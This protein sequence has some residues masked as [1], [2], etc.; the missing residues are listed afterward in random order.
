[1]TNEMTKGMSIADQIAAAEAEEQASKPEA[2]TVEPKGKNVAKQAEKTEEPTVSAPANDTAS[3]IF[4]G[5]PLPTTDRTRQSKYKWD[6]LDVGDAFFV[7]GAKLKSFVTQVSTRNKKGGPTGPKFIAREA[8]H[9]STGVD[10]V[11]VWR[12]S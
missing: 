4:K 2:V 10:G 5:I 7:P 11:M 6:E 1:V 12:K 8:K 9:P 3:E